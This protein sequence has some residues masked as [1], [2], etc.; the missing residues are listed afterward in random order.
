M[1]ERLADKTRR[2]STPGADSHVFTGAF[3]HTTIPP[4]P[5]TQCSSV[6]ADF[7]FAAPMHG[8]AVRLAGGGAGGLIGVLES[9]LPLNG[10]W[11]DYKSEAIPF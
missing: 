2:S 10:K 8:K 9:D 11:W 4:E 7:R 3:P 5:H 1:L 6:A